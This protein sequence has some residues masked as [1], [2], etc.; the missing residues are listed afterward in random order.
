M[1]EKILT[2]SVASYNVERCLCDALESVLQTP[3]RDLLQVIVVDDGSSDS[4]AAIGRAYEDR[5][6]GT[7][8]LISKENGGYGS[9]INASRQAAAGKYY[10]LLDADDTFETG[11]LE[12]YLQ[13]LKESDAD[14]VLS[15]CVRYYDSGREETD[16]IPELAGTVP[17]E[18]LFRSPDRRI[19]MVNFAI[20]T[21]RIREDFPEITEHCFFTDDEYTILCL[22]AAHTAA[23]F[24]APVYRY[25]LGVEGQ[26][27]SIAGR[28]KHFH[29]TYRILQRLL[30]WYRDHRDSYSPALRRGL[31]E[32]LA[33]AAHFQIETYLLADDLQ[34]AGG[35]I[36][37]LE[38]ELKQG[39]E[40]AWRL[41]GSRS[42]LMKFLRIF[43]YHFLGFAA[44]RVRTYLSAGG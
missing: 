20:R 10:K 28:K 43:R 36:R 38:T 6:P 3:G 33:D 31:E 26:S 34:K 5:Y 41:L 19:S 16:R 14:L 4:T 17:A 12:A 27:V 7:V 39:S 9:T 15:P 29:D 23:C 40:E 1:S 32:R 11:N 8:Q 44:G 22:A 37:Q 35:C 2:L 42:R 30:P 24:P 25:H 18:E 13:F 21:D